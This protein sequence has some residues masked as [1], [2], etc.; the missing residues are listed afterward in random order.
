MVISRFVR[1][2]SRWLP[3]ALIV[4]GCQFA[5]AGDGADTDTDGTEAG[6]GETGMTS[7]VEP[8]T[9][10]T[11]ASES[12][13]DSDTTATSGPAG[14]TGAAEGSTGV[15]ACEPFALWLWAEDVA[16][17]DTTFEHREADDLPFFED[18][19]VI[20][21][22]TRTAGEGTAAFRFEMPCTDAVQLWALTWD[23][24]GDDVSNADAYTVGIDERPGEGV[25]WEYG[26]D[27]EERAWRWYRIR[28]TG[29]ACDADGELAPALEAGEHHVQMSNM[30]PVSGQPMFNFTGVAAVVVTNDPDFD[31]IATFDPAR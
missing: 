9:D 11:D 18:E 28:D 12:D 27:N 15:A 24:L 14:S 3:A 8:T 17:R 13:P 25:Q 21:L 23:A 20:F 30:E 1:M 22:R 26:C 16:E 19:P 2:W 31:P 10:P 5:S 29:N 7:N 6:S 4:S